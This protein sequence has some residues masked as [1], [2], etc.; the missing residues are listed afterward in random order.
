MHR[1]MRMRRQDLVTGVSECYRWEHE[2]TKYSTRTLL[3][4]N[5]AE[6]KELY[7][8]NFSTKRYFSREHS[9]RM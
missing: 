2:E 9:E 4:G 7:L 5:G 8:G 1:K 6:Y 3:K